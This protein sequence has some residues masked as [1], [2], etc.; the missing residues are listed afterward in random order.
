MVNAVNNNQNN[1]MTPEEA[2]TRFQNAGV[3]LLELEVKQKNDSIARYGIKLGN[4]GVLLAEAVMSEV[5]NKFSIYPVPNTQPWMRGI[6]N[7]RGNLVPIFDLRE[8]MGIDATNKNEILLIL[9][10]G[11]DAI[12]I[13]IESLP[14]SYDI[15]NWAS[16]LHVPKLPTGFS[17]Y[18]THVYSVDNELWLGLDHTGY[19][20]SLREKVALM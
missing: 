6:I 11:V 5:M 9:D 10:K 20:N 1:W 17:D 18:V 19:F 16:L 12:G 4:I 7:L 14:K 8:L 3:S 15:S 2:L 13:V